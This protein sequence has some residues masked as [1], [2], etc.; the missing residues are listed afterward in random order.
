MLSPSRPR[1]LARGFTLIELLVVI[2]IIAILIGLLLPA[3][4]KVR[5]AA[6]RMS[7]GN[8]LKQAS[9]ALH[10]AHDANGRLPPMAAFQYGGAYYAPFY[11]HLLPFIEQDNVYKSAT[12]VGG[13][14][15]IPLWNTPGQGGTQYLRQTRIKVY[16]CPSDATIGTNA[17]TDWTPGDASYAPNFQVFGNPNFNQG[18]VNPADWDGKTTLVGISDGTSNTIAFAEKLSYCPG[19]TPATLVGPKN[20]PNSAGGSWWLRGIYNSGAFTGTGSP[21]NTDSYPGDRVSPVFGGGVSGDGT[22]WYIGLDAKP[23]IF[24]IPGNNNTSGICDRGQASSPHS[25]LIQVGLA[26]GSVR[27]VSSGVSA[28]TWW[29]ACTRNGGDMVGSDW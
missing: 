6:A 7:C 10:N 16:Q 14:G 8:N 18:S 27:T 22:R 1:A 13:G 25:G 29:A 15:V 3:V 5:E 26:D 2:A 12:P 17:A 23:T 11:F 19:V 4:Q 9:L 21:P 24:G 20:G 28:A